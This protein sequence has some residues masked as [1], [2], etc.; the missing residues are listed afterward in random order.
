MEKAYRLPLLYA[1]TLELA[2]ALDEALFEDLIEAAT[3]FLELMI[4]ATS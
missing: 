2:S 4:D 1:N 3:S